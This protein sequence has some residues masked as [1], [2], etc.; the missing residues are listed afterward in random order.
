MKTILKYQL[1]TFAGP[2]NVNLPRNFVPLTVQEQGG[3]PFIW[4]EVDDDEVIETRT[5]WVCFTGAPLPAEPLPYSYIA[6]TKVGA[7]VL[8]VYL[9]TEQGEMLDCFGCT[10]STGKFEPEIETRMQ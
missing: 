7:L 9:Q 10:P 5:F 2:V 6:T 4:C 1:S 8:H 3:Q